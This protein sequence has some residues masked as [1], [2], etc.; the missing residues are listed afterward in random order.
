MAFSLKGDP[1][2]AIG[3]HVGYNAEATISVDGWIVF[4]SVVMIV[5]GTLAFFEG[6]VA[7]IRKQYL[8]VA[9]NHLIVFDR[10]TWA[11]PPWP[12]ES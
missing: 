1:C 11:G 8:V 6:L 9:A 3:A 10:T 5:V 12:S 2:V 4:T 7:V